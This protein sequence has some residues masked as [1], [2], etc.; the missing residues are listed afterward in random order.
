MILM[1]MRLGYTH[2]FNE[3]NAFIEPILGIDGG[4]L[5]G[6]KISGSKASIHQ[7][8]GYPV[9]SVFGL[10]LGKQFGQP[11]GAGFTLTTGFLRQHSIGQSAPSVDLSDAFQTRQYSARDDNRYRYDVGISGDVSQRLTTKL[12]VAT[13]HGDTFS[14]DYSG[15]VSLSYSF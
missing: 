9:N 10:R 13:S 14:T 11:G 15:G 2:K 1:S 6:Y 8:S 4:Y 7:K 12:H 3:L 5:D